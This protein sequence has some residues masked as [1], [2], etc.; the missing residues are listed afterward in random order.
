[1]ISATR[2]AVIS[3]EREWHFLRR[4]FYVMLLVVFVCG[5]GSSV[6]SRLFPILIF[7]SVSNVQRQG[8]R[9]CWD[10]QFTKTR[11]STTVGAYARLYIGG[12]QYP[13]SV[14]IEHADGTPFGA[15]S[16]SGS[17]I[18][19]ALVSEPWQTRSCI[20]VPPEAWGAYRLGVQPVIIYKDVPIWSTVQLGQWVDWYRDQKQRAF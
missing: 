4:A 20:I 11:A 17:G 13:V 15:G 8:N 18:Q 10:W 6:E 1:M 7:Q 3:G 2:A 19:E 14:G 5:A 9:L 16:P 12:S